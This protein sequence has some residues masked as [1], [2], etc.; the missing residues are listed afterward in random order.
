MTDHIK[1]PTWFWVVAIIALVWNAMG[2]FA[3]FGDMFISEEKLASMSDAKRMLYKT[4]PGWSKIAYGLATVGG[5]LGSLLLVL[6]NKLAYSV[7]LVS[8]LGIVVQMYHSLFIANSTDV[9]GPGAV[10]MPIMVIIIGVLLVWLAKM[11]IK[12]GWLG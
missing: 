6:K 5:F 12:K 10:I 11:G 3:F 1:I 9:Y 8:L 4:N 2:L 7:L